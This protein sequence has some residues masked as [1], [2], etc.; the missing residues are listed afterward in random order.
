[1]KKYKVVG[2][3]TVTRE[4][5]SKNAKSAKEEFYDHVVGHDVLDAQDMKVYVYQAADD[6]SRSIPDHKD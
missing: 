6:H 3:L 1:M 2:F 4:F 5:Y